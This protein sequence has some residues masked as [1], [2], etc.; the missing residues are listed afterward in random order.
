MTPP[1]RLLAVEP[2]LGGS[3]ERFL[4]AWTRRSRHQ[5]EVVGLPPRHW[6]WRMEAA[7]HTLARRVARG[8]RPDAILASDF[9]DVA[10]FRGFLPPDWARVPVVLYLHE[11][12]LT[13]PARD[14]SGEDE[15]D[16]SFGFANLLSCLAAE[17]VVFNSEHHRQELTRAALELCARLPRP[18]P[19]AE[20]A[21]ALERAQVVPVGIE[22][23]D[24]PL[25]PGAP[26]GAPLRVAFNHRFE[27]DKDPAT[28]LRAVLAARAASTGALE[29]VLF[30][31]R[32]GDL[33]PEV[34][35]LLARAGDAILR[36]GFEPDRARYAAGLGQCDL[37]V[38]TARHEFYG[39]ALLEGIATGCAPLA[40]RALAY[41]EVLAGPLASGLYDDPSEL[42][43]RLTEAAT[44][45]AP[46][47]DPARR[48]ERRAA[49][50]EHAASRTAERLDRCCEEVAARVAAP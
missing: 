14:G 26:P 32:F 1:L 42:A 48:A 27:H 13:Y 41:P 12:Q 44:D 36:S 11:N 4:G 10:R 49:L 16:L 50:A 33:P 39:L 22:L 18:G 2:W 46:L 3:H 15:R 5:V 7:A 31:E 28:F 30:G 9:L 6:K 40:P 25:G 8:E 23:E 45:P 29:L 35:E 43:R 34:P 19:R 37:V 21:R 47:R 20:L 17:R 38:S 24:L